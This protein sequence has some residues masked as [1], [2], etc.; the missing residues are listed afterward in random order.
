MQVDRQKNQ[1]LF[2]FVLI[3]LSVMATCAALAPAQDVEYD[4]DLPVDGTLRRKEVKKPITISTTTP[5]APEPPIQEDE[6]Q[7]TIY[8]TEIKAEGR[9]I[10][11]VIDIS[12]SMGMELGPF[13]GINGQVT[14]GNRLDRAKAELT[15]A[16]SS[17]PE[18]FLF[19][20][21]A[22]DCDLYSWSLEL[23]P[24]DATNKTKA[25]AWVNSLQP[26]GGT[27]TGDA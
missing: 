15:K 24:A 26:L 4:L 7:P 19:G 5:E 21:L 2:V 17:L 13:T 27:G 25:T 12:G 14:N 22:Y 3:V 18:S 9:S 8:G 10:Y 1:G 11:F 20:A 23:K 16:I 6:K